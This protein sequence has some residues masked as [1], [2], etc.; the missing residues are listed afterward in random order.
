MSPSRSGRKGCAA[1]R[2]RN[3]SGA[4]VLFGF[5][6]ACIWLSAA[7]TALGYVA[8]GAVPTP[9]AAGCSS[10]RC[11]LSC[12]HCRWRAGRGGF[13]AITL[14][15]VLAPVFDRL[16]GGGFDLILAGLAGGGVAFLMRR[17]G[18]PGGTPPRGE[19]AA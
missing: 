13:V 6:N 4:F 3:P 15:F 5:A 17:M 18:R 1:C 7:A 19:G 8:V 10:F 9:V 16:V 12:L 11:V 2:H 14:G